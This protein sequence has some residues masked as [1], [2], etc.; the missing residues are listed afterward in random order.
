MIDM[1]EIIV[2]SIVLGDVVIFDYGFL[3]N[4][5]FDGD[6][7]VVMLVVMEF[8]CL[9]FLNEV[10]KV[11]V[12]EYLSVFVL[13]N[14]SGNVVVCKVNVKDFLFGFKS[15]LMEDVFVGVVNCYWYV[16]IIGNE[17]YSMIGV[18]VEINVFYVVNDVV[19]FC[20]YCVCIFGVFDG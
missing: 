1:L 19:L 18:N 16:L 13:M 2:D 12:G 6:L 4:K 15:E 8:I 14:L 10:Y 3:V 17:D 20:E 5:C 11:K 7:I 9:V